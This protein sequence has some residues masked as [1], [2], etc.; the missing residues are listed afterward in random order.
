MDLSDFN[1]L[2]QAV[3]S[4][5]EQVI[6]SLDVDAAALT[7]VNVNSPQPIFFRGS[8]FYKGTINNKPYY[9]WKGLIC[10]VIHKRD[11]VSVLNIWSESSALV[12]GIQFKQEGFISYRG[13]PLAIGSKILGVLEVFHRQETFTKSTWYSLLRVMAEQ[14][15]HIIEDAFLDSI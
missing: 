11:I 3:D 6:S 12:R 10:R 13:I 14:A 9:S 2:N 5:L 7:L 15:S 4:L 1:R 8:G